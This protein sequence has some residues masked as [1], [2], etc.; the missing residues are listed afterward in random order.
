MWIYHDK[1]I[2]TLPEGAVGFVYCITNRKTGKQYIG[3]K[4][5]FSRRRKKVAG[6]V[7][8]KVVVK[9]SDWKDYFGSS[10]MLLADIESIGNQHFTR[11]ILNFYK[12]KKA[13]SY[14]ETEEQIK[15]DV[16]RAKLPD[17]TARYYNGNILGKYFHKDIIN[18]R[19]T[20]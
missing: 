1:E 14:A 2:E 13:T 7:N 20:I 10:E 18:G 6:R 5:C 11:E 12:N 9:E 19:L 4:F 15:R 8:R 17:G 3:K 16:L